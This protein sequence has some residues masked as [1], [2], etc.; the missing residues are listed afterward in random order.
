MEALDLDRNELNARDFGNLTHQVL[1]DFAATAAAKSSEEKE[2]AATFDDLLSD[3]LA[4]TYGSTRSVPLIL[5]EEAIRQR[6]RW[7]AGHEAR[8]RDE[9]WQILKV[10]D[11]LAPKEEP[12]TL[13]GMPISGMIDR[14]EEHPK[15]GL[16][17]LDFK[18]KKKPT[19]VRKAHLAEIKGAER[20]REFPD[21]ALLD[22]GPKA[23]PHRWTNLQVPLYCLALTERFP[24]RQ[25]LAGYVQLGQAKGDIA[26]DLWSDLD[27]D[28]LASARDCALGVIANVR[29]RHFW[30]PNESPKYDDYRSLLFGD[31][32]KAIQ[33]SELGVQN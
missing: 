2:V 32:A 23:K 6:L 28:L 17:I 7:W 21:W 27:D 14:I 1:E 18:T 19:P 3:L 10:E 25:L 26:L 30:P 24:N 11:Y 8:Q 12:F 16:R 20:D 15:L 4:T 22:Y 31:P 13:D 5:Q 9:G 33:S 29:A